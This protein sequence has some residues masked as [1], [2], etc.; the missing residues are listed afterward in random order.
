MPSHLRDKANKTHYEKILVYK[1]LNIT[2]NLMSGI[3]EFFLLQPFN[4]K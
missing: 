3:S 1:S 2:E 4:F